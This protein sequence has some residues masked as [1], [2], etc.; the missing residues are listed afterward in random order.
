MSPLLLMFITFPVAN[1]GSYLLTIMHTRQHIPVSCALSFSRE[2]ETDSEMCNRTPGLSIKRSLLLSVVQC[3]HQFSAFTWSL[4]ALWISAAQLSP[5]LSAG[6]LPGRRGESVR[7]ET[8]WPGAIPGT[9]G[10][11]P[12]YFSI[13]LVGLSEYPGNR[14]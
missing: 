8:P 6:P 10:F 14:H 7:E 4:R 9:T 13:S 11:P 2:L 1:S 5:P 12:P 3:Q